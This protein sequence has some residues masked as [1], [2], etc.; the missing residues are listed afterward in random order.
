MVCDPT[1]ADHTSLEVAMRWLTA[2]VVAAL[3]GLGGSAQAQGSDS[4]SAAVTAAQ[5]VARAWLELVDS[6]AYSAS[7]FSAA[8]LFRDAVS[9]PAWERAVREARR[10]FGTFGSRRL[11]GA[12]YQTRLP[13]APPGEYVVL[14]FRVTSAGG[15]PAVETVTPM[16]DQDG[17]W[18]VS[19][20]Y[21]RP[22]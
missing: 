10:P 18:R 11:L 22:E 21:I 19:G 1:Q 6:G 20:Y 3:C 9:K 13:N 15:D 17:T 14:Q 12:S 4:A 16:K 5:P 8:T 7:W 2:L